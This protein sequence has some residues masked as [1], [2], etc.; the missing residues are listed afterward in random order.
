MGII[1]RGCSWC[2]TAISPE[3][4]AEIFAYSPSRG[5]RRGK[6]EPAHMR[7][8]CETRRE[9]GLEE[10]TK[11]TSEGGLVFSIRE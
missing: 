9:A 5:D 2:S 6:A 10:S 1:N 7:F 3:N 4:N 11:A 8:C